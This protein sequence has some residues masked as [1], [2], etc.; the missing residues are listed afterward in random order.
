MLRFQFF[1]K[2]LKNQERDSFAIASIKEVV[3]E[4]GKTFLQDTQGQFVKK[5]H[6][7]ITILNQF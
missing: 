7:L 5:L 3:S 6:T 1:L 4:E 2:G